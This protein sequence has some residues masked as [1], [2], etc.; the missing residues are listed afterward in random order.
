MAE[1]RGGEVQQIK[2]AID[3]VDLVSSYTNLV[4][5]GRKM[6]GL[7]PFTNEKT[8]SFFV[9]PEEGVFYCF[10]SL[11]GGDIFSFVQ[12]VEGVDFKEALALLAERAGISLGTAPRSKRNDS[13]VYAVL[14]NAARTYQELLTDEVRSYL[15]GRGM[16][17]ASIEQ[18]GIGF[19]PD[20]WR[21]LTGNR[22]KEEL[23]TYVKAGL[24]VEKAG[25]H[26]DFFRGRIQFPFYD[27]KGH[28]IGFSGRSFGNEQGPKYM[29][30][31]ETVDASIF[32]K[33]TFLYGLHR[34]KQEIRKQK[35]ALLTEGPIDAIMA[36]QVGYAITVAT[37]GTAVTEDHLLQ[38]KRLSDGRLILAMDGDSAGIKA[39]L[40]VID[41]ALALGVEVTDMKVVAL[42][43]GK[44]PAETIAADVAVFKQAVRSAKPA[45]QFIFSHITTTYGE[46]TSDRVRGAIDFLIPLLVKV[47]NPMAESH[48]VREV[49]TF[50]KVSDE[51]VRD[52]MAKVRSETSQESPVLRR[53]TPAARPVSVERIDGL[54]HTVSSALSFLGE[55]AAPLEEECTNELQLIRSFRPLPEV[56]RNVAA[57]RFEKELAAVD[58]QRQVEMVR[59]VFRDSLK[60]LS[61]EV[62]KEQAVQAARQHHS[63]E[64]M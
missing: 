5:A 7:S 6:K 56:A 41:M 9:D 34:A 48:V 46:N 64:G 54:L 62:K 24:C 47:Q 10:S 55:E 60:K 63:L 4:P 11:K 29:N 36:H 31:P 35:V 3:I 58:S 57:L 61:Q 2:E 51:S 53:S 16:S 30:S 33:S 23:A 15:T 39:T 19:A 26:F 18:W 38:L 44:D 43:D 28:V 22:S 40:R 59:D 52:L 42:P 20:Q 27:T 8:P 50:C 49:A 13:D 37:S 25:R 17:V 45:I 1:G 14:A 21:T 12:E 32:N